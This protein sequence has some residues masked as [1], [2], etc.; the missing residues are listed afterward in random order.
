[1]LLFIL[2]TNWLYPGYDL[3]ATRNIGERIKPPFKHL[4]T[5]KAETDIVTH[6]VYYEGILVFGTKEG[7]MIAINTWNGKIRWKVK[8]EGRPSEFITIKKGKCHFLTD[9]GIYYKVDVKT[10]RFSIC[11]KNLGITRGGILP[12][13]EKLLYPKGRPY[14]EFIIEEKGEKKKIS[15]LQFIH[16][17]PVVR[18]KKIY[19]SS[20]DGKI[21]AISIETGEKLWEFS[22]K[23]AFRSLNPSSA[24]YFVFFAPGGF[25]PYLYAVNKDNGRLA[26]KYNL[27]KDI[28]MRQRE[29]IEIATEFIPLPQAEY[30][31]GPPLKRALKAEKLKVSNIAVGNNEVVLIAAYKGEYLYCINM[32]SG[33]VK[34]CQK[35]GEFT[36]KKPVSP[37]IS[38]NIIY[39][40]SSQ[41]KFFAFDIETGKKIYE[42]E[43]KGK[44]KVSP[45]MCDAKVFLITEKEIYALQGKSDTYKPDLLPKVFALY[46]VYP[47]PFK[48]YMMIRFAIPKKSFV[49]IRIFDVAGRC[50]EV[51]A[52]KQYEPGYYT[53]KWKTEKLP[54]GVYFVTLETGKIFKVRKIVKVK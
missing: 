5:Y 3:S 15:T 24:S 11:K 40:I 20:N 54:A 46:P 31:V 16:S 35:L 48:N 44:V 12:Y 45:I 37:I 50:I 38:G 21:Y 19:I 6:P 14:K 52:K 47:N 7:K 22:T 34:W 29:K 9:K 43:L 53:I 39:C 28:K 1:M 51:I 2:F 17:M 8:L 23:N 30:L 25:D 33:K 49:K 36:G 4:W 10:G 41:G 32:F 18:N 27:L 42:E 26:W 13:G